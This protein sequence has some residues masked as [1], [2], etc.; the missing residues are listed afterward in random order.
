MIQFI[1]NV[2]NSQVYK[3]E[4]RLEITKNQG[5]QAEAGW[6]LLPKDEGSLF[7]SLWVKKKPPK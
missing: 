5:G 6:R 1:Q 4:T 3:A 7:T 2:Q